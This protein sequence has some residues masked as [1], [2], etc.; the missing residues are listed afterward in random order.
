[1]AT[2]YLAGGLFNAAER[3]HNLYLEKHLK[4]LGHEVIL[5]QREALKF[6]NE[7][8]FDLSGVVENCVECSKDPQ[9]IYVGSADGADADSGTCVEYGITIAATGR[10]IVYRTDIRTAEEKEVGVN[11]MLKA[12]GTV[13]IYHPCL[14]T[15]LDQADDYYRE[16]AQKI[17]EAIEGGKWVPAKEVR[18]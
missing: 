1:M 9:N 15:E 14:F 5:P 2:I 11:V 6:F 16:L 12:K 8:Q 7:G 3:L 17:H 10:A 4:E 13:F 18:R